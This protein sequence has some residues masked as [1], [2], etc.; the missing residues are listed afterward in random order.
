MLVSFPYLLELCT[1]KTSKIAYSVQLEL[2]FPVVGN[3]AFLG[4][5]MSVGNSNVSRQFHRMA[6]SSCTLD[7]TF[8]LFSH[9]RNYYFV[10]FLMRWLNIG[11]ARKKAMSGFT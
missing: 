6:R 7:K 11:L 8:V 4:P 10:V 9:S 1:A 5:A 2:E 3:V